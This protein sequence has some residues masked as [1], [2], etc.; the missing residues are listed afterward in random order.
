M[1]NLNLK[2]EAQD[3]TRELKRTHRK[4]LPQELKERTQKKLSEYEAAKRWKI[5]EDAISLFKTIEEQ[6]LDLGQV[7]DLIQRHQP[8]RRRPNQKNL[9]SD[10]QYPT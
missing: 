2:I 7:I 9:F 8:V 3:Y 6:G 4:L 1:K 5:R 10:S